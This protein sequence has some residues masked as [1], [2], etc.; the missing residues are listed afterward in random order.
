[1]RFLA[2]VDPHV[3]RQNIFLNEAFPTCFANIRLLTSMSSDVSFKCGG[4]NES[5]L[6][7]LTGVRSLARVCS[8]VDV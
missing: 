1:M 4:V 2:C 5:F 8:H 7:D 3:D 6:T